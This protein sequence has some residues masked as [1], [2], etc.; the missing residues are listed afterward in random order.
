MCGVVVFF[1]SSSVSYVSAC[2][3][4]LNCRAMFECGISHST[5][6]WAFYFYIYSHKYRRWA[7]ISYAAHYSHFCRRT[8]TKFWS[9]V[10]VVHTQTK[11]ITI[12]SNKYIHTHRYHNEKW[13]KNDNIIALNIGRNRE[14]KTRFRDLPFHKSYIWSNVFACT[15]TTIHY[16]FWLVQ[17]SACVLWLCVNICLPVLFISSLYNFCFCSCIVVNVCFFFSFFLIIFIVVIYSFPYTSI[18]LVCW[19]CAHGTVAN[20][21]GKKNRNNRKTTK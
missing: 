19:N 10:S 12:K 1:Q 21:G 5:Q 8:K 3:K 4:N 20:T 15:V 13:K 9:H 11:N 2:R 14:K 7:R 6:C 17:W 18:W 16:I